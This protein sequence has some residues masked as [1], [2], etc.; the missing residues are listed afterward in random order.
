MFLE[1]I[2]HGDSAMSRAVSLPAA[3]ASRGILEG[4]IRGAGV[5]LPVRGEI[6]EP[7]LEE[8][9][10]HGIRFEERVEVTPL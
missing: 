6:Y 2:P 3:V 7:V 9:E 10:I 8:L 5:T 1:G 4:R